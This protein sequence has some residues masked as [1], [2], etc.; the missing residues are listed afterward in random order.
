VNFGQRRERKEEERQSERSRMFGPRRGPP[1]TKTSDRAPE[2][3][4][5]KARANP[6]ETPRREQDKNEGESGAKKAETQKMK[7]IQVKSRFMASTTR[8]P[9]PSQ[10]RSTHGSSKTLTA[11][12]K[13]LQPHQKPATMPRNE[14]KAVELGKENSSSANVGNTGRRE[15]AIVSSLRA[16][17]AICKIR[18]CTAQLKASD[19]FQK[20]E[21]GLLV[22]WKETQR[23][24]DE[25]EQKRAKLAKLSRRRLSHQVIQVMNLGHAEEEE[26]EQSL[27]HLKQSLFQLSDALRSSNSLVRIYT[28]QHI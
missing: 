2:E 5:M 27:T 16:F 10:V 28:K 24:R 18:Y 25:V 21:E 7:T 19:D 17:D 9:A 23:M 8:R 22:D 12:R 3:K 11:T 4:L 26:E 6:F 14:K 1:Q 13:Q 15:E 20:E